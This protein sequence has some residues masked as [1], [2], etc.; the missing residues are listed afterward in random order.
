MISSYI[1]EVV[2]QLN[3]ICDEPSPEL[4]LRAKHEF[5]MTIRQSFGRTALLLSGGGTLGWYIYTRFE[6]TDKLMSMF[7]V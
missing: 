6:T 7:S 5:F 2:R 3:W 4:D 1:E